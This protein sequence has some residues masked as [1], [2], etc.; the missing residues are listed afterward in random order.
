MVK[1]LELFLGANT[2][3]SQEETTQGDPLAMP[4]YAL[5]TRPLID[6]LSRDTSE[7]RQIWYADDVSAGG[8]LT[9]FKKWWDNLSHEGPSFGYFVNP[10][11]TW[12][13]TK[14]NFLSSAS[15]MFDDNMVNITTDG[16]PV[17]GSPVGKPDYIA[18]FVSKSQAMGW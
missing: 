17:L 5:A 1:A 3:F 12:L 16:R 6:S 11:K 18:D 4:F 15:K 9:N 8:K 10:Q 7:L 13:V 2:L 14:D